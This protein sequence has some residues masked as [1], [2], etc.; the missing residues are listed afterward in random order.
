MCL[1]QFY[2][3]GRFA[4]KFNSMGETFVHS[5]SATVEHEITSP[6]S[7][8]MPQGIPKAVACWLYA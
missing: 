2:G 6:V 3:F 7:A 4:S 1:A 8:S 5:T